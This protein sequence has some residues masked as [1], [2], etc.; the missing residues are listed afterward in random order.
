MLD[1][2]IIK[3]TGQTSKLVVAVVAMVIGSVAPAFPETGLSWTAGLVLSM[4]GYA[5]GVVLIRCPACGARWFWD[6]ILRSEVYKAV[7]TEA[8]CPECLRP[9]KAPATPD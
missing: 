1:N 2:S 4:A 8:E 5:Y 9:G 6:A 3:N 7:F